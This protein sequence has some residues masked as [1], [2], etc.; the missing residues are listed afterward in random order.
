MN[1]H[2]RWLVS[3]FCVFLIASLACSFGPM[4]FG[5]DPDGYWRKET[6]EAEIM[7]QP[8]VSYPTPTAR[9]SSTRAP[10][11]TVE[12]E[13]KELG[14]CGWELYEATYPSETTSNPNMIISTSTKNVTTNLTYSI[15][16]CPEQLFSTHH[17]W[18]T[19]YHFTPGNSYELKVVFFWNNDGSPDC[20]NLIAGGITS[21]TVGDVSIR[22]ENM[23][24]NVKTAPTGE[25][26]DSTT[27]IAPLGEIGDTFT[28]VAHASTGSYGTNARYH[29]K[30]ICD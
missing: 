18:T 23:S 21:L 15:S 20:T 24:I 1:S 11:V 22:A 13:E 12:V 3:V 14:L 25:L 4:Y 16:G 5:D 7:G 10:R 17:D 29:Y 9:T 30:Y 19:Q 8:F 28:I 27:W 6:H 26:S 2:S